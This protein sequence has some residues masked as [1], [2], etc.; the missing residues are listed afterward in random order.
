MARSR[1][2]TRGRRGPRKPPRR[3][4]GATT[5]VQTL[6]PSERGAIEL[7]GIGTASGFGGKR[8]DAETFY[9]FASFT[10]PPST[11]RYDLITGESTLLRRAEVDFDPDQYVVHQEFCTSSDGTRVPVFLA[12]KQGLKR[13]GSNPTLLY[14]YG[15]FNIS[16]TP[17]FSTSRVQWMEMGGILAVANLRGEVET[18]L[19]TAAA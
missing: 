18:F 19:A 3:D 14:A 12:H 8:S 13:D 1:S 4:G 7:P 17:S 15:G 11:Y 6:D 2:G 5:Q 16:I 9:S 10:T